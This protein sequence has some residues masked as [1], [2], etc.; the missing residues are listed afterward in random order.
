MEV[1]IQRGSWRWKQVIRDRSGDDGPL[2]LIDINVCVQYIHSYRSKYIAE[3][4]GAIRS[5]V[6]AAT[7]MRPLSLYIYILCV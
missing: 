2:V 5:R 6:I 7:T 1:K 4:S 3:A